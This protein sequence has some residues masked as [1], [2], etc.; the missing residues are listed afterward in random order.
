MLWIEDLDGW[1]GAMPAAMVLTDLC[2]DSRHALLRRMAS[3]ALGRPLETV[4]ILH[5]VGRAPRVAVPGTSEPDASGP[6][7]SLASRGRLSAAAIAPGPVGIDVE[8][9]DRAGE[10]PWAVLHPD[11]RADLEALAHEPRAAAFARLWSLKEAY[12]KALHWGLARDPA[13]FAV[14][15]LDESVA[16]IDDPDGARAVSEATTVWRGS[17]RH[18]DALSVAAISV[19]LLAPP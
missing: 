12:L 15:F 2:R 8:L 5:R 11:E 3:R 1:D 6:G 4:A 7:L 18:A 9:L 16:R 17:D 19:V 13:G 10:V 14:R